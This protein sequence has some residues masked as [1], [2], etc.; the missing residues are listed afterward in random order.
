M[1]R[2]NWQRTR[3][4]FSDPPPSPETFSGLGAA[5]H[6]PYGTGLPTVDKM[7]AVPRRVGGCGGHDATVQKVQLSN[8]YT[9]MLRRRG[10]R[11]ALKLFGSLLTSSRPV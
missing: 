4:E 11:P 10:Y 6:Y 2:Y 9:K 8:S 7:D 3:R 1:A 5:S